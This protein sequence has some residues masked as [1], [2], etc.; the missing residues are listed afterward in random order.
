MARE[1][2][3]VSRDYTLKSIPIPRFMNG[4]LKSIICSLI[5][6]LISYNDKERVEILSVNGSPCVIDRHR[7]YGEVGFLK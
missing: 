5:K 1:I 7:S 2:E 6:T 4:L 3:K